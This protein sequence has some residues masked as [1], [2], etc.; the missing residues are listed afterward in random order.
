M[1]TFL[2][3]Y[4]PTLIITQFGFDIYTSETVLNVAD[5]VTY[6]P[7]MLIVD[8]TKR[9]K[10]ASLLFLTATIASIFLIFITKPTSCDLCA[11]IFVQLALVFIFRSAIS[12]EF[13]LLAIYSTELYPIRVRNISGSVLS[14][15][16]TTSSTLSPIIMGAFTR[17][18]WNHFILF[19]ILGIIA[20]GSYM[21]CPETL[22]KLCPE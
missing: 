14:V 1:A 10:L 6:Y 11:T 12:M 15:F 7:L 3:Y 8:K 22:G 9:R 2:M 21:A 16:G 13:A 20:I 17:A 5:I 4:G 18:G 19:T